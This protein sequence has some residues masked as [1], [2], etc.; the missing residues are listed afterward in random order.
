MIR[1]NMIFLPQPEG[2]KSNAA[3]QK[4]NAADLNAA[5]QNKLNASDQK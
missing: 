5:D 2:P 3:D 4:F 1:I